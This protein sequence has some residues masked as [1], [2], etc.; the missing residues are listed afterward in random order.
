MNFLNCN[1]PGPCKIPKGKPKCLKSTMFYL[2]VNKTTLVE[3]KPGTVWFKFDGNYY[4]GIELDIKYNMIG[5]IDEFATVGALNIALLD[6][7]GTTLSNDQ[8]DLLYKYLRT[9]R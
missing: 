6:F 8:E 7:E 3:Q 4:F 5:L 9:L 2:G 1:Y